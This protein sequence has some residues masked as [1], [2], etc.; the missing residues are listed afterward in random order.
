MHPRL[1]LSIREINAFMLDPGTRLQ[2][3]MANMKMSA[4][5]DMRRANNVIQIAMMVKELNLPDCGTFVRTWNKQS[6]REHQLVG[7]KAVSMKFMFD[8]A[9]RTV[10]DKIL[11]HVEEVGWDKCAW[12]DDTLACKK[13][14]PGNIKLNENM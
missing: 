4:R 8:L 2:A 10:L 1:W 11:E 3:A 14:Y 6:T 12:T 5:G 13:M 7:R 9:P